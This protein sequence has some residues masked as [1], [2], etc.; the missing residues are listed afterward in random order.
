MVENQ[1]EKFSCALQVV[2][3]QKVA[4]FGFLWGFLWCGGLWVCGGFP[5]LSVGL[6]WSWVVLGGLGSVRVV[7]GVRY[8]QPTYCFAF[9]FICPFPSLQSYAK[10][11]NVQIFFVI[12][13]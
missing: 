13:L 1:G 2:E 9:R 3:N 12:F 8:F 10:N 11:Q 4:F 5:W 6:E 7:L